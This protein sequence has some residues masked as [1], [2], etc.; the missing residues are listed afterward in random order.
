MC[1]YCA[2]SDHSAL[3]K[4]FCAPSLTFVPYPYAGTGCD[5]ADLLVV[6]TKIV[7]L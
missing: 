5:G 1:T 2:S 6:V 3:G 7:S 4:K